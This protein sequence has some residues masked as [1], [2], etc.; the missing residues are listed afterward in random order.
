MDPLVI[1]A[2][3][4]GLTIASGLLGLKFSGD[5]RDQPRV[6]QKI[7]MVEVPHGLK[8]AAMLIGRFYYEIGVTPTG[9]N[10]GYQ[11]RTL[12]FNVPSRLKTQKIGSTKRDLEHYLLS[13]GVSMIKGSLQIEIGGQMIISWTVGGG[14]LVKLTDVYRRHYRNA[15][16]APGVFPVGVDMSGDP[17]CIVLNC[18]ES[19]HALIIGSSGSGKTMCSMCLVIGAIHCGWDVVIMNPKAKPSPPRPGLWDL[20]RAKN[21]TYVHNY[22]DMIAMTNMIADTLATRERPTLVLADELADIIH[23]TGKEVANPLGAIAAKG[24]EYNVHMVGVVPKTTKAVLLDDM[25]HANSGAV[26]IGMRTNTKNL[27]QYG[28]GIGNMGLEMLA[29]GGH[30]KVRQGGNI[31][32]VQMALPDNISSVLG[33]KLNVFVL[34]TGLLPVTEMW[35]DSI[36]IGADVSKDALRTYASEKGMGINYNVV[37]EQFD[38]LVE[39]SRISPGAKFQAGKKVA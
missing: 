29:G 11:T 28:A 33:S 19:P 23:R 30:S 1:A 31:A 8:T 2:G 6:R 9:G 18:E 13:H 24:R 17:F 21:V 22:S 32:E 25:L 20:M 26:L 39:M 3:A 27:S 5:G 10:V 36:P 35:I 38:L 12:S 15:S 14:K 34:Q 7:R 4:A 37:R 16:I